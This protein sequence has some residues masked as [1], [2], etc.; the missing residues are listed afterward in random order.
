[1]VQTKKTASSTAKNKSLSSS[2]ATSSATSTTTTSQ[3]KVTSSSQRSSSRAETSGSQSAGGSTVIISEVVG[4]PSSLKVTPSTYHITPPELVAQKPKE[5]YIFGGTQ[6]VEVESTIG[7]GR[8][9][10]G[11]T[12]KTTTTHGAI[13]S[14]PAANVEKITTKTT[15]STHGSDFLE[16]KSAE[17][18][19]S[20]QKNDVSNGSFQKTTS[21]STEQSSSTKQTSSFLDNEKNLNKND[22]KTVKKDERKLTAGTKHKDSDKKLFT[23]VKGQNVSD[24]TDALLESE[25]CIAK[26]AYITTKKTDEQNAKIGKNQTSLISSKT[27]RSSD[28]RDDKI[29]QSSP[30]WATHA[31]TNKNDNTNLDVKR[32]NLDV[33]NKTDVSDNFFSEKTSESFSTSSTVEKSTSS[34]QAFNIVDGKEVITSETFNES[35]SMHQKNAAEK[36]ESRSGTGIT[37]TVMYDQKLNEENITYKNDKRDKEPLFDRNYMNTERNVKMI[38]NEQPTEHVRGTFETTRFDETLNKYVTDKRSMEDNKHI[39]INKVLSDTSMINKID[40]KSNV[41][42][43]MNDMLIDSSFTG[44]SSINTN[45]ITS[46]MLQNTSTN[47]AVNNNNLFQSNNQVTDSSTT[48]TSKVFDEKTNKWKVIDEST[49][50]EKNVLATN[51]KH[52]KGTQLTPANGTTSTNLSTTS[53]DRNITDKK[54]S[55]TINEKSSIIKHLYDEKSKSWREVDEKTITSKRPSLI[56]YVSKGTDGKFTTIYKRKLFDKRSGTWKVVDEKVYRNNNFNEHIPEVIEDETNITTTTYTTKV[57]DTKTNTWKVVDEKTFTDRETVVPKD[58]A[59][60]IARDQPDIANITT[61]T[62]L[63]KVRD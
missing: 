54:F 60:E 50:N 53:H 6:I 52:P 9:G 33:T 29:H 10:D 31:H 48:Y 38:G 51:T 25:R 45:D 55:E 35:G 28:K 16:Q 13:I 43:T 22:E 59:D 17:T 2:S 26:K 15:S 8:G 23:Y 34:S 14:E 42:S 30:I 40:R 18:S 47:N 58:I 12:V 63:T 41:V 37:P 11:R 44:T 19:S 4:G 36:F 1:M 61:T 39:D 46:T 62:E 57:F 32:T 21:S 49:L 27:T 20:F 5:H 56:R 7:S 3:S 24:Q